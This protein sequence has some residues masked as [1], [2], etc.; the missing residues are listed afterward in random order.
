MTTTAMLDYRRTDLRTSVLETPYWLTSAEFDYSDSDDL[1]AV[2]FSFPASVY[3]RGLI[4][5]HVV[6]CQVTTLGNTGTPVISVGQCTL[7]TEAITTAG[8][9]T[10]VDVDYYFADTEVT[11]ETAG[12]YF[13]ATSAYLT[14]VAAQTWAGVDVITPADTTVPCMAVYV[15]GGTITN[16]AGR[17][18]IL[19][20]EVPGV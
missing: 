4:L 16:G 14:A 6:C 7:A 19:I 11:E 13:P 12:Y 18:H 17:L 9:T 8:D 20:S 1:A 5:L 15:T 10:D 2:M 3:T